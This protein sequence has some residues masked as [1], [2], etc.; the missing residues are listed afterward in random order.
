MSK[1]SHTSIALTTA[2]LAL[3]CGPAAAERPRSSS[4][5][6]TSR[7]TSRSC[8]TTPTTSPPGGRARTPT[9]SWS[10][11]CTPARP[12]HVPRRLPDVARGPG[13]GHRRRSGVAKGHY[14]NRCSAA[15]ALRTTTGLRPSGQGTITPTCWLRSPAGVQLRVT[16]QVRVDWQCKGDER[17]RRR[18]PTS[19]PTT[20]RRW[21]RAPDAQFEIPTGRGYGESSPEHQG[22]RGGFCAGAHLAGP[23]SAPTT[24]R[25]GHLHRDEQTVISDV[26]DPSRW[27]CPPD[28]QQAE[29]P[30]RRTGRAAGALVP[31][32][33]TADAT[34]STVSLTARARPAGRHGGAHGGGAKAS[35]R[36]R[37]ASRS[38]L[39]YKV[40]AASRSR[41]SCA[42]EE[43]RPAL[44]AAGNCG[45]A[46]AK[47]AAVK[48]R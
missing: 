23:R 2:A 3:A 44:R 37:R 43:G 34:A 46:P 9:S 33:G 12:D 35:A 17:S 13:R 20:G 30:T 28:P 24:G 8:T 38:P 21:Q 18:R 42:A 19:T 31:Q 45:H 4:C 29:G 25:R 26:G 15:A 1:R 32:G 27:S 36:P 16:D 11:T 22:P 48:R 14:A 39:S 40:K 10:P 47:R 7:R 41:S 6:T 5:T